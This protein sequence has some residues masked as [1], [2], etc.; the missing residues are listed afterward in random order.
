MQKLLNCGVKILSKL[1][2]SRLHTVMSDNIF[3][4]QS[5]FIRSRH[6]FTNKRRQL[7]IVHSSASSVTPMVVVSLDEGVRPS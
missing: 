2:A 6:S 5:G 1:L 7:G 3:M 4:D